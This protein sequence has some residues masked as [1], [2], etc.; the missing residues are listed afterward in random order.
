[1][2]TS[3][4]PF[5]KT[6]FSYS[7]GPVVV[8]WT[9]HPRSGVRNRIWKLDL[10]LNRDANGSEE[11]NGSCARAVEA[12]RSAAAIRGP[13]RLLKNGCGRRVRPFAIRSERSA[14]SA[15]R[16]FTLRKFRALRAKVPPQAVAAARGRLRRCRSSPMHAASPSSRRLGSDPPA[17]ATTLH[18]L[19]SN[20]LGGRRQDV[21]RLP[22]DAPPT[23]CHLRRTLT[24]SS[25]RSERS[26]ASPG[27]SRA[28]R[29]PPPRARAP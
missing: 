24:P 26:G 27:S 1:M 5:Q 25:R 15:G 23:T 6:S 16:D 22:Y 17:L 7:T 14:K 10:T 20:L 4:V 29:L 9:S 13:S 8:R 21:G 11:P 19:F 28:P 18:T 2:T 3:R 12:A